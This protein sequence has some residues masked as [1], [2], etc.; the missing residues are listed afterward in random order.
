M[1]M[2][3]DHVRN[4]TD[5]AE[6]KYWFKNLLQSQVI[7]TSWNVFEPNPNFRC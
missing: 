6:H 5:R 1:K 7:F 2:S 3:T 4:N